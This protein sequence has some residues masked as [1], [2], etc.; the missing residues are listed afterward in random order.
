MLLAKTENWIDVVNGWLKNV[1]DFALRTILPALLIF[2][3][4]VVIIRAILKLSGRIMEKAKLE[5]AACSLIKTTLR[6]VLYILLALIV[7]SSLGI[8]VTGI[9]ALASV[10][11]LAV[12]LALQNALA[13]VIGGFTLLYTHP[14]KSGDYVEIAGKSGTVEEIGMSYTV[15]AT[16]D[17]KLISIPNSAVVAAQIVN[18][19]VAGTRRVDITVTASYDTP[20]EQVLSALKEAARIPTALETPAPFTAVKNYGE[21][22][23]EYVLQIWCKSEDYWTTL[24]DANQIG[25]ASCRERV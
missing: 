12:S 14:F 19:T 23:I 16:P 22:S 24:F 1:G 18:Y 15:L 10:L 8:D 9:I 11:T 20:V 4:G 5:K 3:V 7:A 17:N 6:A 25:R 2:V 21:S 13:N